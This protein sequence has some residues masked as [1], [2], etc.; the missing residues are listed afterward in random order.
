MEETFARF[1]KHKTYI[2]NV[3]PRTIEFYEQSFIAFRRCYKGE[4]SGLTK[5]E[6]NNFV[7]AL[8]ER[9][10]S[11]NGANCY[12][13]GVNSFLSWCH[14]NELTQTKLVIPK[15]KKEKKLVKPFTQMQLRAIIHYKPKD[16]FQRRTHTLLCLL[17]DTGVRISEALTLTR[18]RVDLD[19]MLIKVIGKG[20]KERMVPFS[21]EL[22][23]HLARFLNMHHHRYVFPTEIGG[24]IEYQCARLYMRNLCKKLGIEGVRTSPHTLRHTFALEYMKNGGNLIWL[25]HI[26]GHEDITT[27]RLYVNFQTEDLQVEHA[28]TSLLSRLR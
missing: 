28:R 11:P 25:Q 21:P 20:S 18:D 8:R 13:R 9:G 5:V 3:S 2:A 19:N 22:R 7:I 14:Q 16:F 6:L 10:M 26:L 1:L 12:I 27:T 15:L 17:I 4:L 24:Q 23:K